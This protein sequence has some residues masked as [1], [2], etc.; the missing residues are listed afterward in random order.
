MAH[1]QNVY[2]INIHK[3]AYQVK[4]EIM[5]HGSAGIGFYLNEL[6]DYDNSA[7]YKSTGEQVYTYYCPDSSAVANHAVNIVGWDDNFPAS[8][9]RF[10]PKGNGAWLVR[11]SWSDETKHDINSY[12]WL[13]YYDASINTGST[14]RLRMQ[15]GFSILSLRTI[16][17]LIIS[18][19]VA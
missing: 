19:T 7:K 12:F 1:L 10:K 13:S 5:K 9:F 14:T 4:Q 16:M 6:P 11:N 8:A 15:P 17:I 3:N 2:I 18:M